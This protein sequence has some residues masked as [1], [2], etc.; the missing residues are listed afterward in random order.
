MEH[1]KLAIGDDEIFEVVRVEEVK[2]GQWPD[3]V[4]HAAGG[5]S[6]IAPKGALDRQFAKIK[7]TPAQLAGHVVRL[8]RAPNKEDANKSWWNLHLLDHS[9]L[10][11]GVPSKRIQSP[12]SEGSGPITA[13]SL[14]DD[15][16]GT[17]EPARA[18]E[19]EAEAIERKK[20]EARQA[21]AAKYLDLW[22]TIAEHQAK[23][24]RDLDMPVDGTAVQATAATLWIY[25]TD[26]RLV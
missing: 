14:K 5:A 4:L 10:T 3:Y 24:A 1:T 17:G 9:A 22:D 7:L 11:P 19:S 15:P 23:K 16:Q 12:A 25:F 8:E 20:H 13:E 18:D 2:T 26:R 6:F 21:A